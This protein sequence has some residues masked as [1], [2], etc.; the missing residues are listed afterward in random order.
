MMEPPIPLPMTAKPPGS[1]EMGRSTGRLDSVRTCAPDLTGTG[2]PRY[3]SALVPRVL[4]FLWLGACARQEAP[5]TEAIRPVKTMVV[6]AGNP[7]LVRSFPARVEAS[8]RVELAFQVPGLLVKLPVREGQAV[9]KGQVI[10]RLRQDEFQARTQM[11]QGQ[12]DQAWTALNARRL[13]ER[14][15]EQLRREA[16]ARAAAAK[17]ANART[18]FDRYGRLVKSSAVSRAEY[19]LAATNY[20][21]AEEEHKAA[22]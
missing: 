14:T 3:G 17:L 2:S 18:E 8:K 9:K 5:Q 12:V 13:A 10:A 16:Q 1:R 22:V 21:V 11:A 6:P 7:P 4:S 15:E 19:E 20:R